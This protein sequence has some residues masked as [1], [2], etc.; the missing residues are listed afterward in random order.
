MM[1][2]KAADGMLNMNQRGRVVARETAPKRSGRLLSNITVAVIS[3]IVALVGFRTPAAENAGAPEVYKF[4]LL[5]GVGH[6]KHLPAS[7]QLD[8]CANDVAAMR[9]VL[10]Q[11]FAFPKNDIIS[12]LDEQATS[13]SIRAGMQEL[14]KRAAA[15]PRGQLLQV[16]FHFSGHGSQ[17][18]DQA[19]GDVD[20]DEI[21]GLDETLVP[22]DAL[23]QGG[24]QDL[25][26][27]E[28]NAFAEAISSNPNAR[29]CFVLDCCH[30][31]SGARG[32]TKL[33]RLSRG[34]RTLPEDMPAERRVREKQ[35][36]E[37]VVMI[38]ACRAQE[39]EPEYQ[40]GDKTY[41]LLTRFVVQS[42]TQT[43]SVSALNYE[44]LRQA[45]L[46]GYH[47][48]AGIPQAP[49]PQLE[50]RPADL[51][52]VVLGAGAQNDL[53]PYYAVEQS[54]GDPSR[55]KLSAGAFHGIT[56]GS[57]FEIV[58]IE[59]VAVFQSS[60]TF[61]DGAL[62]LKIEQVD[63]AGARG[64]LQR[65][66]STGP[67]SAR[68]P[69]DLKKAVAA[70]R[71]HEVG[72]A[73]LRVAVVRAEDDR[74]DGPRLKQGAADLSVVKQAFSEA[75]RRGEARWVDWVEDDSAVDVVLR[76]S[77]GQGAFFPATGRTV[78]RRE[79]TSSAPA[80]LIGGWG[81]IQLS[82]SNAPK[83]IADY[84]RRISLTRNLIRLAST[85]SATGAD[86]AANQIKLE[87]VRVRVDDQAGVVE[88]GVWKADQDGT[89][90]MHTG[91]L[92][93]LRIT[94]PASAK[95]P[96]YATVL[97]IGP[98]LDVQIA[99]PKQAGVGLVDEQI[100]SP[101]QTRL[102]DGFA[103]DDVEGERW[104]IVLA[105]STPRDLTYVAQDELPRVRGESSSF[106][107][108]LQGFTVSRT[109]GDQ[110]IGA[111]SAPEAWSSGYLR[112]ESRP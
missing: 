68:W 37:R 41:G 46:H 11:R 42:L 54:A 36:P 57:L 64:R 105:T 108:L 19:E 89:Q 50:G 69:R 43:K 26:D 21:D 72:D 76:I 34:L 90:T 15:V 17:V 30:S 24:E 92:Y 38:S 9:D 6:Y 96:L 101:N 44:Q 10:Q 59:Q 3:F 1:F 23:S 2:R 103:C 91:D 83:L 32:T 58:A 48:S 107:R 29:L 95:A 67:E 61:A 55:A 18:A 60:T 65:M 49:L 73:G 97:V 22:Y 45:I 39:V 20:S 104:A 112:W 102:S 88:D 53:P 98:N 33:R 77:D 100:L 35:L 109:R 106:D 70:E 93:A 85:Q 7:E 5:I 52:S 12:L 84:L 51:R 75:Q 16:V 110:R 14:T 13:D 66:T 40:D 63:G 71:F 25:R 78:R 86:L 82:D 94:N 99:F 80:A 4:A 81:P 8:G 111:S 62:L 79:S 27:D 28:L 47:S 87:L 56:V 31:G 74:T